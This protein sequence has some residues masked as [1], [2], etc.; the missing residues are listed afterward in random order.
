MRMCIKTLW[1]SN[2]SDFCPMTVTSQSK[3]PAIMLLDSVV[4]KYFII[5]LRL[6]SGLPN[7]IY[8]AGSSACPGTHVALAELYLV[9]AQTL[10]TAKISKAVDELGNEI[11]PHVSYSSGPIR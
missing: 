1:N 6:S 9:I 2:L 7:W 5:S 10:A 11:E 4:G 8:L 3:T